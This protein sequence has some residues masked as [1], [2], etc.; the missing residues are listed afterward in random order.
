VLVDSSRL[1]ILSELTARPMSPSR[2][3]GE[4]GGELDRVS[5]CFRELAE[6]G[7]LELAEEVVGGARRGGIEHVYRAVRRRAYL[8]NH[9]W[10]HLS[11]QS[12][13]A[14]SEPT[15]RAFH[16][17]TEE[18]IK[19]GIFNREIDSHLCHD[20]I[21]LDRA[22][23][24][25]VVSRLRDIR[26][27]LPGR[28]VAAAR[29][30]K[31]S[32]GERIPTTLAVAGF[33]SP[34]ATPFVKRPPISTPYLRGKGRGE[35]SLIGLELAHAIRNPSRSRIL[36]ELDAK[37]LS[38]A[39]FSRK[40][41]GN[42]RTDR[43]Y[44]GQLAEWG[45]IELAEERNSPS[46]RLE[47]IYRPKERLDIDDHT[48]GEVPSFVREELSAFSLKRFWGR[49]HDA[50]EAETFSREADSQFGWD[51]C[52]L[53]RQG[54]RELMD[55][56]EDCVS[57]LFVLEQEVADRLDWSGEAPIPTTYFLAGFRT[58]DPIAS[59]AA[60]GPRP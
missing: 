57:W 16:A 15:V 32:E 25:P 56:L 26:S 17:Q 18:G 5:R 2:F 22:A 47:R 52:M 9:S 51:R 6:W 60:A 7:Y 44:F 13:A 24:T 3:V 55:D 39:Q 11:P 43:R 8:G 34:D 20:T 4:F 54:W 36:A 49:V 23:W 48:W 42:P 58:P 27:S 46:G 40:T 53:D 45:L 59:D 14:L 19:E 10:R 37:P 12:R 41:G 33:R 21:Q 29:R 35:R 38:A 1:Q 28:A 31:A 30:L 50:I